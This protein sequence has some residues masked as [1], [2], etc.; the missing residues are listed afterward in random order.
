MNFTTIFLSREYLKLGSKLLLAFVLVFSLSACNDPN[1]FFQ[2]GKNQPNFGVR[3]VDTCTVLMETDTNAHTYTKNLEKDIIGA[4]NDPVMGQT[5]AGVYT[6]FRMAASVAPDFAQQPVFDSMILTIKCRLNPGQYIGSPTK[7]LK[8]QVYKVNDEVTLDE[9]SSQ[10]Y[11]SD[12]TFKADT[13][14]CEQTT[15]LNTKDTSLKLKLDNQLFELFK[16]APAGTFNDVSSFGGTFK[17]LYIKVADD[18]LASGAGALFQAELGSDSSKLVL[19]YRVTSSSPTIEFD[20]NMFS[21]ATRVNTY[22]HQYSGSIAGTQI[23]APKGT[24][25]KALLQALGGTKIKISLPYLKNLVKD[26]MVALYKAEFVFP[27][28]DSSADIYNSGNEPSL[29]LLRPRD[30]WGN[31]YLTGFSD[32]LEGY[33]GGLYAYGNKQYAFT[34]TKYLQKSLYGW[35]NNPAHVDYGMNLTIPP[36]NPTAASRITLAT[37]YNKASKPKLILTFSKIKDK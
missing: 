17:G 23:N 2:S 10:Y 1:E 16:K 36:S 32:Y 19:Y 29:L 9:S 30:V 31:D 15:S 33:Y 11:F 24:Y 25:G 14:L 8:W 22:K 26:S 34:V 37:R 18:L 13:K 6:E 35:R 12:T 3:I 5:N 21:P 7:P 20:M 28:A 4:F 27:K